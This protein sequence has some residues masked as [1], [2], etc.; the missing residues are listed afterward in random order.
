MKRNLRRTVLAGIGLAGLKGTALAD[1][2]LKRHLA[3]ALVGLTLALAVFALLTVP[4]AHIAQPFTALLFLWGLF[5]TPIPVAWGTWMTR[6]VPA[7]LE[8]AGG[9]QV[10][11]IH[12]AITAGASAGGLLFDHVGFWNAFLLGALLLAG[13]TLLAFPAGKA[14]KGSRE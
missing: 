1:L 4:A 5:T 10:A 13:S 11:L 9:L 12:F 3:L 2:T 6:V 14:I 8:A 7:E